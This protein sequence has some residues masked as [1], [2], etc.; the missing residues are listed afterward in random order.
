MNEK[1]MNKKKMPKYCCGFRQSTC[2]GVWQASAV[3]FVLLTLVIIIAT[4]VLVSQQNSI[5]RACGV[6]NDLFAYKL[7]FNGDGNS[8]EYRLRYNVSEVA[9]VTA[10]YIR[11]PMDVGSWTGPIAGVLCG[12][13][14]GVACSIS[15]AGETSG[16]VRHTIQNGVA[17][18]GVDVR[19]VTQPFRRDPELYYLEIVSSIVAR[20]Q[21]TSTCG[22]E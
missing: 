4:I 3:I 7:I 6:A 21:L 5:H 16:L 13:P 14:L 18:N 17:I 1:K 9:P 10:L 2:I 22:Y 20:S 8:I 19:T 11:G 12:A 15:V